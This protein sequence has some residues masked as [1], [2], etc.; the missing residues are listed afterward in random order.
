MS[1]KR[2]KE[3]I[4]PMNYYVMELYNS[5]HSIYLY[6]NIS[7]DLSDHL[8][9]IDIYENKSLK[10]EI[11]S[12]Y[13][14]LKK[15]RFLRDELIRRINNIQSIIE[16]DND[17]YIN[18]HI[19]YDVLL[20]LLKKDINQTQIRENE[21]YIRYINELKERYKPYLD[22][23]ISL[24]ISKIFTENKNL[25]IKINNK[26]LFRL[27]ESDYY[28]FEKQEWREVTGMEWLDE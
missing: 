25:P 22:Y 11:F 8:E 4:E 24:I 10:K 1:Q 5:I 28:H 27:I 23:Y 19:W 14:L 16:L 9:L 18:L 17:D 12:L 20:D 21:L 26:Q 7:K 13:V 15:R 3:I 6:I 2:T